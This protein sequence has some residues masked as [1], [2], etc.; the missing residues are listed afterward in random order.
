VQLQLLRAL[1]PDLHTLTA[2]EESRAK[3][4]KSR[5]LLDVR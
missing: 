1:A 5:S 4:A 2:A 3:A